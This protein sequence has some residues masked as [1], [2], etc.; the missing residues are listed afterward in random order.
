M[1]K[2]LTLLALLLTLSVWSY[3][4]VE[5]SPYAGYTFGGLTS[6][7]YNGYRLR[8]DGSA[9]YGGTIGYVLPTDGLTIELGYNHTKSTIKQDGGLI[10]IIEPTPINVNYIT[11]GVQAPF[12]YSEQLVPYGL[13]ALGAAQ[14]NPT[15]LKDDYWRFALNLGVGVK[16][17][18][19]D[20]IGVKAQAKLYMPLYFGGFGFGCG[21]GT[22]GANCGGGAGFGSEIVQLDLV[23]GL[24]VK[25]AK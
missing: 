4:Q 23:G 16:Y 19:T 18:F 12:M 14:Y 8:I 10:D 25:I 11:L 24:V 9:N 17:Y 20:V 1:N 13:I 22:G 3:G 21:I 15:E 2:R 5:I 6:Y 7:N